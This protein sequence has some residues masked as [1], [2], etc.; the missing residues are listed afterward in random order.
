MCRCND[1]A[2]IIPEVFSCQ[3]ICVNACA[4]RP[5]ARHPGAAPTVEIAP[6]AHKQVWTF[7]HPFDRHRI[8]GNAGRLHDHTLANPKKARFDAGFSDHR[9]TRLSILL[10]KWI[11]IKMISTVSRPRR[12]RTAE[13]HALGNGV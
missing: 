13:R 6:C 11:Y 4:V 5:A 2:K 9:A 1:G 8:S 3:Q 12:M 7:G 10:L